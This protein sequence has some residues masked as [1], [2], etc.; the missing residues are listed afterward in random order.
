MTTK[1]ISIVTILVVTLL[2]CVYYLFD[3]ELLIYKENES[4]APKTD[5]LSDIRS[6]YVSKDETSP[7][8]LTD[9]G[10]ETKYILTWC[11]AYGS[12]VYGWSYG[13]D[14]F[15]SECSGE[16]R[17]FLTN[18]RSLLGALENFDAIMFH[19]RSFYFG[20]SPDPEKRRPSQRY[21]HWMFVSPAFAEY[22]RTKYKDLN[23]F[24]NWSMSY[25]IDSRFPT[26]YGHI[27]QTSD[28][29]RGVKL[30]Q[31]IEKFGEDNVDLAEKTGDVKGV[32]A[33]F[34]SNCHTKSRR[35]KVISQ[36]REHVKI[37]V[38]VSAVISTWSVTDQMMI[39]ACRC[40]THLTNFILLLRTPC[41]ETTSLRSSSR[42]WNT[43]SFLW[44]SM[45]ST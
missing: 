37:D 6:K 35:D 40:S 4:V 14:R 19:Q 5:Y 43:M 24:F 33:A 39:L 10:D 42:F 17:C 12:Q 27:S 18:N 2:A 45:V 20:D 34:I 16:S 1:I 38:M 41:V 25:R 30:D 3:F 22:D 28:P 9:E 36:L 21:V 23:N 13:A 7:A 15:S 26:P 29:P 32:A 11:E 44:S 8:T 31:L